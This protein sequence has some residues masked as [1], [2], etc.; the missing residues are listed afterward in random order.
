MATI[1]FVQGSVMDFTG[2]STKWTNFEVDTDSANMSKSF[3]C[4]IMKR[5]KGGQYYDVVAQ[6]DDFESSN[7]EITIKDVPRHAI[8]FVSQPYSS[9][10]HLKTAFR[11]SIGIPDDIFPSKWMNLA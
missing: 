4:R 8:E 9:D 10:Q 2:L 11:H 1:C 3:R 5:S 7:L 6:A